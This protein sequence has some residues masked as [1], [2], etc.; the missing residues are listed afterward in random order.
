MP[1][2]LRSNIINVKNDEGNYISIDA[3]SDATTEE[4]IALIE[5]KGAEEQGKIVAD[6]TAAQNAAITATN[7]ANNAS[8][9][10][11]AAAG[12]AASAARYQIPV[13]ISS[14]GT[15]ST[16][17]EDARTALL[18]GGGVQASTNPATLGT[19]VYGL[20]NSSYNT[21][22]WPKASLYGVLVIC[23]STYYKEAFILCGDVVYT[24]H[25]NNSSGTVFTWKTVQHAS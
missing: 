9:S 3:A 12:S 8:N 11:N 22:Y 24:G 6:V 5:Q 18:E 19:G 7:A 1:I 15:G 23:N 25:F 20:A 14:G 16:T 2:T 21:T 17:A 10:A 4:R 13:Q